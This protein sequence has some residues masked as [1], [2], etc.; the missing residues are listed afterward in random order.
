MAM[1]AVPTAKAQKHVVRTASAAVHASS[2]S[3][4]FSCAGLGMRSL[5]PY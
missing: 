3:A 5:S 4:S 2:D 1:T